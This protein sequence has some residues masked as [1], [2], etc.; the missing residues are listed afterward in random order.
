MPVEVS[1]AD[2]AAIAAVRELTFKKSP[3]RNFLVHKFLL[4]LSAS[5][6]IN[7]SLFLPSLGDLDY[8][9]II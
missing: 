3:S 1:Q 8:R 5:K 6:L 7:H 9:I 2:R 4:L